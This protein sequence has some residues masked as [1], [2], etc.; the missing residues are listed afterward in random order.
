[1][2]RRTL[3]PDEQNLW[4]KVAKTAVPLFPVKKR[5]SAGI[6]K[7]KKKTAQQKEIAQQTVHPFQIGSKAQSEP[8]SHDLTPSISTALAQMPVKMDAKSFSK[9]KRGKLGPEGT[10][11]LHGMTVAQAH[12]ALINFVV[13]GHNRGLRLL[14]V[15][16]GKGKKSDDDGPIPRQIGVLRHQVPQWLRMAPLAPLV[17]Q[18]TEAHLKHG[19]GGAYYVYLRRRR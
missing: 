2:K 14:L 7:P 3:K 6:E 1:M 17:L 15:I 9:M 10:I 12:G 11:D 5:N 13:G 19:G 4:D 16:T 8:T 18:V